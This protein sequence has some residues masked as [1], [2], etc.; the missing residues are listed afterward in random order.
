MKLTYLLAAWVLAAVAGCSDPE[1]PRPN[2]VLVIGDTLRADKL[3]C[4]GGPAGLTPFMDRIAADGVRFVEARA[5]AP[6]TLPS[7]ASLLTSL[8]PLEHGAGGQFPRFRAMDDSVRTVARSFADAGYR[9]H[10]IVN[11]EFLAPDTFGVTRDFATVDQVVHASNVEVRAA[12]ATTTAALD[13]IDARG[14]DGPFFLLVHYFDPHCVYAPPRLQRERWAAP[15]D[16]ASQWTF[17]TRA[18]MIAIRRGQ[19][20]PDARTIERAERLYEG[21]VAF[22]DAQIGRLDDGLAQRDLAANTV[23]ALTADHGEEFHDHAGFEHGHTLFDELVRVPLLLRAPGRLPPGVVTTPARH[24]D[25]APTLC[26]LCDVAL[27]PQFVGRSLIPLARGADTAPRAT[28]AHGNFWARPMTSWAVG[29]WKLV[30]RE[31]E[32]PLLF[33]LRTDPL[34]Q[35]DRRLDSPQKLAELQAQLAA[36]QTAMSAQHRGEAAQLDPAT[37]ESLAGLGYGDG[38]AVSEPPAGRK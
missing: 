28:L 35:R 5:H 18:Q 29:G 25:V 32:A 2:V 37:L 17:G 23:F 6:W 1:A 10:A 13:W 24:V 19:L 8:H 27:D 4:Q 34:E 31:D 14:D 20:Q 26:E 38:Q 15:E 36:A 30:E 21:E 22:L 3:S 16:R 11:V 12:D 33:D 9:T 7:T